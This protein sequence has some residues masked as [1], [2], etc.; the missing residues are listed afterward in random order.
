MFT[1]F[2]INNMSLIKKLFITLIIGIIVYLYNYNYVYL[3]HKI[4]EPQLIKET[5]EK[6][7]Y[8]NKRLLALKNKYYE[9]KP[10]EEYYNV[11]IIN[12][13]EQ[14]ELKSLIYDLFMTFKSANIINFKILNI[15]FKRSNNYINKGTFIIEIDRSLSD[16]SLAKL[17]LVLNYFFNKYITNYK[18]ISL[19]IRYGNFG[20]IYLYLSFYK[21]PTKLKRIKK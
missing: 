16:I 11:N 7:I 18:F 9:L 5:Y 13:N 4:S 6:N 14:E 17:R 3:K 2:F 12:E 1:K 21:K 15:E 8:L 10:Y 19:K 20:K